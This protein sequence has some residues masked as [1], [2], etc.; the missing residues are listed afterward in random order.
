MHQQGNWMIKVGL[1]N[2]SFSCTT[3]L[4]QSLER[5][6]TTYL[7]MFHILKKLFMF[8]IFKRNILHE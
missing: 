7:N 8:E 2:Q 5:Q 6:R 3:V 1:T 4:L